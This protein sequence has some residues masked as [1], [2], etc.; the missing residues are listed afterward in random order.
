VS[1]VPPQPA[2][3]EI[4]Q[5]FPADELVV[6]KPKR[7]RKPGKPNPVWDTLIELCGPVEYGTRAHGKRNAA[8]KDLMLM[9]A[10][11]DELRRAAAAYN[12]QW[13]A[14]GCTDMALAMHF[15]LFRPKAI[16]KPCEECGVGGG[17]HSI[18]CSH[19]T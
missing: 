8:V 7:G 16:E 18:D 15:P 14:A 19:V 1:D 9:K 12:R 4:L 2:E 5:L 6:P 11:P 3:A 13:P 17:T 10:T